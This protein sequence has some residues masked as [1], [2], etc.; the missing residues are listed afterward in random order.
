MSDKSAT[1]PIAG[2]GRELW[3]DE[4]SKHFEHYWYNARKKIDLR[5]LDGFGEIAVRIHDEGNTY[6]HLD[7]L[8]TLWQAVTTMPPAQAIVE[9]G[10]YQ[11]GSAKFVAEVLRHI[12]RPLPFY[13][14]DTYEG[15][16]VVDPEL[17]PKHKV[18]VQFRSTSAERVTKYLEGYEFVHVIK[19]DIQATAATLHHDGDFG[20]VH[21]DVDVHP[22]TKFCLEYFAPRVVT[23]AMIVVDDYGFRTCPGAKKAVDDFVAATPGYRLL[24]LLTGQAILTRIS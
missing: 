13:V 23:G 24:H 20:F 4:L 12:G 8:Y 14:C 16:V 6:L 19:G 1:F 21:I 2:E 5:R 17:D 15:H 9:I 3:D 10:A 22:I 18:G 11:G 7:R